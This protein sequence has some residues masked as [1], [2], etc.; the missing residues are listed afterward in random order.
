MNRCRPPVW[1][2]PHLADLGG[3]HLGHVYVQYA[4]LCRPRA[5]HSLV[6]WHGGGLTGASFEN[7]PGGG[8]GWQWYFLSAGHDVHI[9]DGPGAGRARGRHG[10]AD[11]IARDDETLWE[12][13]RIGPPG[14][15]PTRRPYDDGRFPASAYDEFARQA[16]HGTGFGDEP[17][18]AAH[19]AALASLGPCVLLT[20]SAAG[21][22]GVRSA[23]AAPSL[24][25]G[26]V[27]VEPS[28]A[29]VPSE[30]DMT[31]LRDVPHLFIW[32]DHLNLG[33]HALHDSARRFHEAL[34]RAG[35]T[36]TWIDLPEHG[37][38][39]NSHL[40]ML[41]DNSDEVADLISRWMARNGLI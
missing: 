12:L 21:P 4:R 14:S 3:F 31:R 35:G 41:D 40:I 19:D 15:Y 10:P 2:H 17:R 18:Q 16:V 30:V 7:K 25:R 1:E 22:I 11:G 6:C 24:V 29:P 33:W 39:G 34:L 38:R 9:C 32:G 13:F 23:L 20:H 28:G 26:H 8:R 37:Q 5:R 27:L 36:S